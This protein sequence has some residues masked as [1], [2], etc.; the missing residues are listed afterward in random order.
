MLFIQDSWSKSELTLNVSLILHYFAYSVSSL[1]L[2]RACIVMAGFFAAPV[3]VMGTRTVFGAC[4]LC[5]ASCILSTVLRNIN[6]LNSFSLQ[7]F[8]Y[9]CHLNA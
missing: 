9:T 4:L 1:F 3:I 2:F 6:Y 7:T 5:A 8:S